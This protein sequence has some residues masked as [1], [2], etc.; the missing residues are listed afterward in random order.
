MLLT[1][2]RFVNQC[3]WDYLYDFD[4]GNISIGT[5]IALALFIVSLIVV[6]SKDNKQ[7]RPEPSYINSFG[8]T[9]SPSVAAT[10]SAQPARARFC[11]ECGSETDVTA[12]FCGNCGCR[13]N[14]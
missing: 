4:D 12:I 9:N 10:P 5:W 13:I 3:G 14:K 1:L 2:A 7:F 8:N 11:P 6:R